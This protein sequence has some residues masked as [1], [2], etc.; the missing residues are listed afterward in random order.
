MTKRILCIVGG[1]NAGGAETFLMKLYRNIDRSK[2]QMDFAVAVLEQGVYDEEILA[3]GGRIFKITPKTK[4]LYK[5]FR[6]IKH[7]VE[8]N[9]YNYVLRVSQHSLSALELLAAK[10]GGARILAFRSSNTDCDRGRILHYMCRFMPK[11]IANV[12][13]APSKDSAEFMFG[14]RLLNKGEVHIL[15]NAILYDEYKYN[16]EAR[17]ICISGLGLDNKFVVGHIGRFNVQKNHLF[18]LEIFAHIR[19]LRNNAKLVLIG[20]GELEGQIKEK[21]ISL[22]ISDD[23]LFL[24]IRKDIPQLLAAMDVL[25]FPSF[26]EG[27]PNVIIEAQAASLPCLISDSIIPDVKIT[28]FVHQ[29]SIKEDSRAW[30][31]KALTIS[32]MLRKDTRQEFLRNNYDIRVV[33]KQFCDIIF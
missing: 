21:A 5:N 32:S 6:D 20:T 16:Q 29:M 30:A 23:I 14:K 25:I 22:G 1:M 3:L 17:N 24:G 11:K 12:R 7:I 31:E 10:M 26:Y 9:R 13:I 19:Q 18:L 27:M 8:E 4:C 15:H 33:V 28:G 2:F